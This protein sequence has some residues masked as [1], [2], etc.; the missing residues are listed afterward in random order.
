MTEQLQA[1]ILS[2]SFITAQCPKCGDIIKVHNQDIICGCGKIWRLKI[3]IVANPVS[4][5]PNEHKIIAK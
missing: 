4:Y 5:G 2:H 1:K 3:E